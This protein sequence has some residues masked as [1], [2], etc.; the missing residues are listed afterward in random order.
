LFCEAASTASS[1]VPFSPLR[2]GAPAGAWPR[3]RRLW[4]RFPRKAER[5]A[6]ERSRERPQGRPPARSGSEA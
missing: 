2:Y 3:L 4:H 5:R 6:T 1:S